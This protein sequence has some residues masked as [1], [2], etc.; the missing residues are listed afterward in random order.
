MDKDLGIEMD[1]IDMMTGHQY[2][3]KETESIH[4]F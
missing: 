4:I 3:Q 1:Y 2:Y